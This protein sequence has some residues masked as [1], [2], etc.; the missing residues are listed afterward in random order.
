MLASGAVL[1]LGAM[2]FAPAAVLALGPTVLVPLIVLGP[3]CTPALGVIVL[4]SGAI[5]GLVP[6]VLAL[7]PMAPPFGALGCDPRCARHR[8]GSRPINIPVRII[9]FTQLSSYHSGFLNRV[10]QVTLLSWLHVQ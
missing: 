6:I 9:F 5:F 8:A 7:G 10:S 4:A 2:V 3:T 1:V